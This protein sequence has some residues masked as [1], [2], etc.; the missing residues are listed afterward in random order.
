MLPVNTSSRQRTG[1]M[2]QCILVLGC[3]AG[4][5][6]GPN[7][8]APSI[9]VKQEWSLSYSPRMMGQPANNAYWWLHFQDPILDQLIQQSLAENLTLQEAGQRIVEANARLGFATGNLFPQTQSLDG[10]FSKSRLSS[11]TANFFEIPGIFEQN[12]RPENWRIGANTVWE[13]DFWGRYRRAIESADASLNA[14]LANY[15]DVQVILLSQ[16]ATSYIELRT[17]ERRICLAKE[18][19]QV[20][21][22][23]LKTVGLKKSA[24]LASDIDL[25]QAESNLGQT[26]ALLPQLE[27]ERRRTSHRLS[28]LLGRPPVD[29]A[30]E[31][32]FTGVVPQAPHNLAFGIPADLLRRRPDI[33]RAE[34]EL[35]AQCARI[36]I[37]ET[38]LYPHISLIGSIGYS[39][40]NLSDLTRPSSAVAI[41]A[42]NFSWNL[43]NYRRLKNNIAAEQ[44]IF[45][46]KAIAYKQAVL[47]AQQEAENA[48]TAYVYGFDR[49]D[50]LIFSVNSAKRA[51]E[52]M[53]EA[54]RAGTIDY[55]R[56]YVLQ[57]DLVNKQDQLAQAEAAIALSLVQIFKAMGGGWESPS[58]AMPIYNA[59]SHY[60]E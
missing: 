58:A 38:E 29:L 53:D 4:C 25:A 14:S 30:N 45:E 57:A 48:Q 11:N 41:L 44:A 17:Y 40:E 15:A 12:T 26:K 43:F 51:V 35:A 42:P 9:P 16:V 10:T 3:L 13:L 56:I 31:I 1:W 33:R 37:A 32:G 19:L 59:N 34:R 2:F 24:G 20:Q 39:S 8:L 6:V 54:Y 52:R 22:N 23:T 7:Y 5:K 47:V 36:G 21:L 27:I 60:P 28:V 55:G 18:N 49:A 50:S 46:Q